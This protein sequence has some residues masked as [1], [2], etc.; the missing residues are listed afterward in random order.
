MQTCVVC[1]DLAIPCA[2]ARAKRDH[3]HCAICN[4][5]MARSAKSLPQGEAMCQPCRRVMRLSAAPRRSDY[6]TPCITC[7]GPAYGVHC[8]TCAN[9]AKLNVWQKIVRHEDDPHTQRL[10]REQAAPGLTSTQRSRLLR[11]WKQ[12]GR[13][14]TYCPRKADTVDHVLPLVRGG[15]NYEGNLTPCC[16]RC[17]GSKGGKM[18]AE[19]RHGHLLPPRTTPLPWRVATPTRHRVQRWA[20]PSPMFDLCDCGQV[21]SIRARLCESCAATANRIKARNRYRGQVGLPLS[22]A[23]WIHRR[24]S[25]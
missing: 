2:G 9:D 20:E 14:C 1:N 23:E 22:D 16:R 25:A 8:R 21:R 5:P 12:Q 13:T 19:W 15:T 6:R 3:L 18:V 4:K 7:A 10:R 11:K 17:N 24:T